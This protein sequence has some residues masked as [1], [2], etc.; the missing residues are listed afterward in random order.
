MYGH[1]SELRG[2]RKSGNDDINWVILGCYTASR[3]NSLPTF[4]ENIL[5][6]FFFKFLFLEDGTDML[7]RN[8]G[9]K[10]PLLAA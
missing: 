6:P 8:I 9:K 4:Q 10:L 3:V 5:I 7:S 1:V 2:V